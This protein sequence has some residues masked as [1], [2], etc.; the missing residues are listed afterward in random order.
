M[1]L[2]CTEFSAY[3]AEPVQRASHHTG[4]DEKNGKTQFD[5]QTAAPLLGNAKGVPGMKHPVTP[6]ARQVNPAIDRNDPAAAVTAIE[7][8]FPAS[9]S[10]RAWRVIRYMEGA[11][12]LYAYKG[13]FVATDESL[14][15]TEYGDGSPEKP[16]G[17]PR[18]TGGSLDELEHWLEQIAD[19]YDAAAAIIPGWEEQSAERIP[20]DPKP[21]DKE[22]F[23]MTEK[24]RKQILAIRDSGETN[25]LD[26]R[27]VQYIANRKGYYELVIYLEEHRKEY[28]N[29]IMTG[30]EH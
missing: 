6:F 17:A 24:I 14:E 16:F 30:S 7:L 23:T 5:P 2:R 28:W 22:E 21:T 9:F 13:K 20:A 29:F 25:M 19:E 26:T 18:W 8:R 27:T 12:F 3:I 4:G 11:M 1:R 15:L 10:D